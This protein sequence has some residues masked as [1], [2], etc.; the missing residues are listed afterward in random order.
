M[1]YE[2]LKDTWLDA[3][4]KQ[5]EV[6]YGDLQSVEKYNSYTD[7][8][9]RMAKLIDEN[10]PEKLTAFSIFLESEDAYVRVAYAICLLELTHYSKEL[11]A[12]ALDVIEKHTETAW[13]AIG[14]TLW[15]EDWHQGKIPTQ[16]KVEE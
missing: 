16:Y 2:Q 7:C 11:E 12:K 13:D 6:D 10:Y 5:H 9:R 4:K 14:Y 1:R 3:V 8:Y 15:L